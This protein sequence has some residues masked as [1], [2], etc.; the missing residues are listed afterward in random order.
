M[1][2]SIF[3]Q[4][5]LVAIIYLSFLPY[6]GIYAQSKLSGFNQNTNFFIENKGQVMDQ[7]FTSRADILYY[8]DSKGLNFHIKKGWYIVS[9]KQYNKMGF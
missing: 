7:N 4:K 3:S 1:K 5:L 6:I 2:N 9:I 8:G